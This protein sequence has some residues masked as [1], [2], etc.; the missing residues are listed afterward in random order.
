MMLMNLSFFIVMMFMIL[1]FF[2][3]TIIYHCYD[4]HDMH[5]HFS[6]LLSFSIVITFVMISFSSLLVCPRFIQNH[7]Q[8]VEPEKYFVLYSSL[9]GASLQGT[10]ACTSKQQWQDKNTLISRDQEHCQCCCCRQKHCCTATT[11]PC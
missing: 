7:L 6:L 4:V 1:S 9:Q 10:T 5:C 11:S 8:N 3:I 2:I